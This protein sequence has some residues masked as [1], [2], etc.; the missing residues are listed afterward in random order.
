MSDFNLG[1]FLN[2]V[3]D[4]SLSQFKKSPTAGDA[5]NRAGGAENFSDKLSPNVAPRLQPPPPTMA[6]NALNVQTRA[7]RNLQMNQLASLDRALY[8]KDLMN[9]PKTLTQLF[10]ALQG[11][12]TRAVALPKDASLLLAN[13]NLD[14]LALLLQQNGKEALNKLIMTMSSAS[15]QGITDLSEIK[16][17]MKLI[18]ACVSTAG[19]KNTQTIKSLI[20]LYL[21]WLPLPDGVSFELEVESYEEGKSGESE[22]SLTI[23]IST[24]NYGN[25]KITLVLVGGNS[26]SIFIN[27]SDAFPKDELL[28]RIKEE[29][30]AHSM[31]T[32]VAFEQVAMKR[33]EN[34]QLSAKIN[35]ENTS[36]INPF[37]L[38]M[39]H[40]LIN[41]TIDLD[42]KT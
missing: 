5:G 2:R 29:S 40:A 26:V 42:K 38:L 37:L 28:K 10:E 39:A 33:D 13:L 4:Y 23:L 27:C 19:E 30:N 9:L 41:H 8:A 18:N 32:K 1:Q 15:K 17:M 6:V 11:Q 7:L 35:M 31:Q 22:S 20:L 16:D 24:K 25:L 12:M 3:V 34:A 36:Q 14:E 21:P